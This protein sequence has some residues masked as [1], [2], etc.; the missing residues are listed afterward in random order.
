MRGFKVLDAKWSD[1]SH[2]SEAHVPRRST[3]GRNAGTALLPAGEY[4][5]RGK[6]YAF[7]I[8]FV[9]AVGGFL[10]GYD[11]AIM[12]G[13]NIYLRDQFQL[14][15]LMFG[16][17]SARRDWDVF[18]GRFSGLGSAITSAAVKR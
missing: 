9:S 4:R 1:P 13:A 5:L 2:K 18:W 12:G 6:A 16:L 3:E 17:T 8:A 11:L 15:D 10:F 14:N 7:L